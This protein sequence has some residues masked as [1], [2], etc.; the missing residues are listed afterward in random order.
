MAFLGGGV[1][2]D[3]ERMLYDSSTKTY[4]EKLNVYIIMA[5]QLIVF[6]HIL[7]NFIFAVIGE[8]FLKLV[9]GSRRMLGA[10]L[11]CDSAG[12]LHSQVVLCMLLVA[13]TQ[14]EDDIEVHV[15]RHNTYTVAACCRSTGLMSMGPASAKTWARLWGLMHCAGY[16]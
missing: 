1:L 2:L 13:L 6:I 8:V 10:L 3:V 4:I 11:G 15:W 5:A 16:R 9:G 14:Y 12:N 7:I